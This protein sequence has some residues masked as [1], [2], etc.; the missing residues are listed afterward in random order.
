MSIIKLLL[1]LFLLVFSNFLH[2]LVGKDQPC[3]VPGSF[4]GENVAFIHDL[5]DYCSLS[6]VPAAL[7]SLDQEKAFDRVDW[8]FLRFTL[9]SMG[10]GP[11]FVKWV[12]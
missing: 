11:F 10:F 12:D 3:G 4:I 2:F 5:V 7:I 8:S 6:C 1:A 9:F